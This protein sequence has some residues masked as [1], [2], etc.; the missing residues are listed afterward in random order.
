MD[1]TLRC[2][3]TRRRASAL[4]VLKG[5]KKMNFWAIGDNLSAP[6]VVFFVQAITQ[7]QP[8]SRALEGTHAT[9]SK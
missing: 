4:P 3:K 1:V 8:S 6:E 5:Y 7:A 2:E 9:E